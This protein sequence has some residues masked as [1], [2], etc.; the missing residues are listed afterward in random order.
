MIKMNNWLTFLDEKLEDNF[1]SKFRNSIGI[2]LR[3]LVPD[4]KKSKI[5]DKLLR[6]I[7]LKL[8]NFDNLG[9]NF[10]GL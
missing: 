2:S 4:T 5:F 8:N 3:N 6:Q 1:S 7:F 10:K 9:L